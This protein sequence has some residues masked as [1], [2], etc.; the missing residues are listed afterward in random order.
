MNITSSYPN[1][2]IMHLIKSCI[3]VNVL[4]EAVFFLI[5]LPVIHVR[6]PIGTYTLSLGFQEDWD[7]LQLQV[8]LLYNSEMSGI[9]LHMVVCMEAFIHEKTFY[10]E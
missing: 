2:K 4:F 3:F 9:P 7:F 8:A 10:Q 6:Y 5:S 1:H